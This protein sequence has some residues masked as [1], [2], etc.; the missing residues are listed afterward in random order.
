MGIT[1]NLVQTVLFGE[2]TVFTL[3]LLP[4]PKNMK[5][6]GMKLFQT[7]KVYRGFLHILYVLFAMIL[8]MF[9]DSGYK[10]Y[11]GEEEHNPF[12]L[13]QAERNLYLTG[14]TLFLALIFRMFTRTMLLLFKEEES[15]H[16]LRKQSM[17]QKEYVEKMIEESTKKD[18][19]IGELEDE[20]RILRKKIESGDILMKQMKNNQDEYFNLLDRYNGLKEQMKRESRK[21]K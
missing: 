3:M 6:S 21:S 18:E 10:M 20:A 5:R 9:V 2:M 16:L 17:N 13:Y 14:F 4:I 11:T 8:V 19:R 7:S 12:V 1:T 15:A